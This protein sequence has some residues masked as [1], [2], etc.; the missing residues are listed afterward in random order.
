MYIPS[1][2]AQ[3]SPPMVIFSN[4]VSFDM[5]LFI[6]YYSASRRK[7]GQGGTHSNTGCAP[8]CDVGSRLHQCYGAGYRDILVMRRSQVPGG[9]GAWVVY[10]KQ[11]P[12]AS[13]ELVCGLF[14]C[15]LMSSHQ[16]YFPDSRGLW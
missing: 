5:F 6:D 7:R 14:L 10:P 11:Q 1:I 13:L 15:Q 12:L 4:S 16:L 3:P 8:L 2:M 9:L